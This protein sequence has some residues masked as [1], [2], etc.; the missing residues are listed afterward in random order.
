[1]FVKSHIRSYH[2]DHGWL[3]EDA[4]IRLN[5]HVAFLSRGLIDLTPEMEQSLSPVQHMHWLWVYKNA[6]I[7]CHVAATHEEKVIGLQSFTSLEE[8]EG[9]YFPHPGGADVCFHQG[10]VGFPLDIIFIRDDNIVHYVENTKVGGSD[11][12]TCDD[13]DGVIEVNAGFIKTHNVELGDDLTWFANSDQDLQNYHNEQMD[14]AA[15]CNRETLFG[16]IANEL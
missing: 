5:E 14:I 8:N 3:H 16:A 7:K 2:I 12:W 11:K 15:E 1:M 10:S 13:C 6:N 4:G 9:L